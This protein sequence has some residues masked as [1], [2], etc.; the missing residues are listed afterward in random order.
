MVFKCSRK[1]AE[2]INLYGAAA[3]LKLSML[4]DILREKN[5]DINKVDKKQLAKLLGFSD[6]VIV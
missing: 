1:K 4:G 5:I 6:M 3:Y 2:F